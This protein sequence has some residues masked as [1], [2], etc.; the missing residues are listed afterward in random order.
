MKKKY[1]KNHC[2][3]RSRV[4]MGQCK[5]ENS[6]RKFNFKKLEKNLLSF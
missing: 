4:V 3:L 6:F 2:T 5:E 1:Q